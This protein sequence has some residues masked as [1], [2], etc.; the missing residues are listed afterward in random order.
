MRMAENKFHMQ[1]LGIHLFGVSAALVTV[2]TTGV[3]LINTLRKNDAATAAERKHF[4]KYAV[5]A[6]RENYHHPENR[7]GVATG[8]Y[9]TK[10]GKPFHVTRVTFEGDENHPTLCVQLHDGKSNSL[11]DCFNPDGPQKYFAAN[12]PAP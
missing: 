4:H 3:L 6:V 10:D 11:K 2:A 1:N 9:Y 7:N 12:S 8:I 5:Q